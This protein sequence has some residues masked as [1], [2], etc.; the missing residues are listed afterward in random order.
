N[1]G[2]VRADRPS[3]SPARRAGVRENPPHAD[4]PRT[5]P[6]C[7]RPPPGAPS[8]ETPRANRA[9]WSMRMFHCDAFLQPAAPACL[10]ALLASCAHLASVH[11]GDI[12]TD[13]EID[14]ARGQALRLWH[15]TKHRRIDQAIDVGLLFRDPRQHSRIAEIGASI[16]KAA[17]A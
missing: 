14:I 16:Q 2:A 1:R 5:P 10:Y 6:G 11:H 15:D 12:R 17:E 8:R 13:T 4:F 3:S 7:R 9:P